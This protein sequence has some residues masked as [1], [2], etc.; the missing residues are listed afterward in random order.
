M[1]TFKKKKHNRKSR[2][3]QKFKKSKKLKKF[4]IF[5]IKNK[6]F[7]KRSK[8]KIN[9]RSKK[10]K[11]NKIKRGGE[12]E[13]DIV[14]QQQEDKARLAMRAKEA[15]EAAAAEAARVAARKAVGQPKFISSDECNPQP[16]IVP[17]DRKLTLHEEKFGFKPPI[18]MKNLLAFIRTDCPNSERGK[19]V[20][21]EDT[22]KEFRNFYNFIKDGHFGMRGERAD[23]RRSF[24]LDGVMYT[25][26]N[27]QTSVSGTVSLP[28]GGQ[29][30][31]SF[32]LVPTEE[33]DRR[34][35]PPSY[36]EY[37]K[38]ALRIF[39]NE[40]KARWPGESILGGFGVKNLIRLFEK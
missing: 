38:D 17:D 8:K 10:K 18:S 35:W 32:Y 33:M 22:K 31:S 30:Q 26:H 24:M 13:R 7:N 29:L 16:V 14:T 4:K 11:I 3:I 12:G 1:Q 9:K 25:A 20:F 36:S 19:D 39:E 2:K 15:A 21:T 6:N 27:K 5:T 23:Q 40:F 28:G 37:H 34:R